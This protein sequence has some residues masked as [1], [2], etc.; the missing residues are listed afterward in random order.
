M[1]R[2]RVSDDID[3]I[4]ID[5]RTERPSKDPSPA[6]LFPRHD[7]SERC[8]E[9]P[10]DMGRRSSRGWDTLVEKSVHYSNLL[11]ARFHYAAR[12]L[13]KVSADDSAT[14]ENPWYALLHPFSR[15]RL[16]KK[17]ENQIGCST[18]GCSTKGCDRC[19]KNDESSLDFILSLMVL[20][21]T[22]SNADSD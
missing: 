15:W 17:Y 18:E 2:N 16:M 10:S 8:Q 19:Q 5:H 21:H 13:D 12:G 14:R 6:S 20:V 9:M 1:P 4:A 22:V 3:H 7:I 11:L